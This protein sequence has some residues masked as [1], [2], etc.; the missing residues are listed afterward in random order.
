MFFPKEALVRTLSHLIIPLSVWIAGIFLLPNVAAAAADL[1]PETV[2]TAINQERDRLGLSA[3]APNERLAAAAAAKAEAIIEQNTFAHAINGR[4]FSSWI[5]DEGYRYDIVGEN[6]AI[7]FS[8]T[9]PLINA[10]LASPTHRQNILYGEYAETGIAV[11]AGT[12]NEQPTTVIVQ[13]FGTPLAASPEP[14]VLGTT[15]APT[16]LLTASLTERYAANAAADTSLFPSLA[17]P[18]SIEP[19]PL[20]ATAGNE[21]TVQGRFMVGN[22]LFWIAYMAFAGLS[23]GGYAY[24]RSV[25]Q[26]VRD[27]YH[28]STAAV[29]AASASR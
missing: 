3:L 20:P 24:I 28:N 26:F 25:R 12:W 6:L 11:Y 5:Q 15:A 13:L 21:K 23:I 1:T 29:T 17:S 2:L 4:N 16:P 18:L 27:I 9:Q 19:A 8:E 7:H 22:L 10:W 14:T